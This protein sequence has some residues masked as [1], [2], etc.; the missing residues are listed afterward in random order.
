MPILPQ[1]PC[2]KCGV[3]KPLT[4]FHKQ[5]KLADG[6]KHYCKACCSHIKAVC[7]VKLNPVVFIRPVKQ[8]LPC[9]TCGIVMWLAPSTIAQ[10]RKHCSRQCQT[11]KDVK[12]CKGC[13]RPII[14]SPSLIV[15]R[16]YCSNACRHNSTRQ[17]YSC[18]LCGK[19]REV[20]QSSGGK[21]FCSNSCRLKWFSTHF[22]G[23]LSPQW[24]G[25]K[26]T[27]Y[28]ASWKSQRRLARKRDSFT[29]QSC[30]KSRSELKRAVAVHHV[31]PF[32]F[33]GIVNHLEANKL[34]NL[35]CLCD[36]CHQKRERLEQ[37]EKRF[38]P[39]PE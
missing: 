6:H 36:S 17:Q 33:F 35:I 28:G 12:I 18:E 16:V 32:R 31:I 25:G 38:G 37:R 19:T 21:R 34:S 22:R 8:P 26:R 15:G 10:G 2:T 14:L 13:Q 27:Y 23:E 3:I 4:D 5:A 30:S 11:R 1:K 39:L 9:L 7:Y 29:C 20:A 24:L